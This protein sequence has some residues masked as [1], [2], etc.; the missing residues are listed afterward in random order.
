MLECNLRANGVV[1]VSVSVRGVFLFFS[2]LFV[3][4]VVMC[5]STQIRNFF[6]E[7][8]PPPPPLSAVALPAVHDHDDTTPL[9]IVLTLLLL[10]LGL[11][12]QRAMIVCMCDTIQRG[13]TFSVVLLLSLSSLLLHSR[14]AVFTQLCNDDD[15]HEQVPVC[16]LVDTGART[17]VCALI[18]K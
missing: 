15:V 8:H 9:V 1:F 5:A 13:S 11:F 10:L 3:V 6:P 2:A 12:Y 16:L 17:C 18:G 14:A 4:F 7:H